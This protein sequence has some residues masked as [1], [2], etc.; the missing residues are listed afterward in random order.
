MKS[1][2]LGIPLELV[3]LMGKVPTQ[4]GKAGTIAKEHDVCTF[5]VLTIITDLETVELEADK[6]ASRLLKHL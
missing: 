3:T 6:I 1:L 4:Q 5:G 2:S